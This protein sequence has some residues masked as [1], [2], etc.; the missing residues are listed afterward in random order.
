MPS[1]VGYIS[2]VLA[3]LLGII[4][5]AGNYVCNKVI[6]KYQTRQEDVNLWFASGLWNMN[7]QNTKEAKCYFRKILKSEIATS[8]TKQQCAI[9]NLSLMNFGDDILSKD[10]IDYCFNFFSVD[11]DSENA[12]KLILYRILPLIRKDSLNKAI[13]LYNQIDE[14]NHRYS[15]QLRFLSQINSPADSILSY[16]LANKYD[17][18]AQYNERIF[19]YLVF[20]TVANAKNKEELTLLAT[21]ISHRSDPL[22]FEDMYFCVYDPLLNIRYNRLDFRK[23]LQQTVDSLLPILNPHFKELYKQ[24]LR[25]YTNGIGAT[26][27][28]NQIVGDRNINNIIHNNK[29]N[30]ELRTN[31]IFYPIKHINGSYSIFNIYT[32]IDTVQLNNTIKKSASGA[33]NTISD[34]SR[35]HNTLAFN[36]IKGQIINVNNN[37]T[38]KIDIIDTL[39]NYR[40]GLATLDIIPNVSSFIQDNDFYL[41]IRRGT[42]LSLEI[43]KIGTNGSCTLIPFASNKFY[44]DYRNFCFFYDEDRKELSVEFEKENWT[45][46]N[47]VEKVRGVITAEV[48]D[49]IYITS[50]NF[51]NPAAELF[52]KRLE[53][54]I[55]FQAYIINSVKFNGREIID[56]EFLDCI[57]SNYNLN[58]VKTA[59]DNM[60]EYV[61]SELM[62][63]MSILQI[64][65]T[66][67]EFSANKSHNYIILVKQTSIN[68]ME[69]LD[70]YKIIN[71]TKLKSITQNIQKK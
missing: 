61:L 13:A 38:S 21:A 28:V 7:N 68:E 12:T 15:K 3:V 16:L 62:P 5:P 65:F 37:I 10:E 18:D 31:I 34:Q 9:W 71:S 54:N 14:Y 26:H 30:D 36:D 1:K 23:V 27:Y 48:R 63:D 64:S 25:N 53:E 6:E 24:E 20:T 45:Q 32:T 49:S 41:V 66:Q 11:S 43:Y 44:D 17:F 70:I 50:I 58:Y 42:I 19:D 55:K 29:K 33:I 47:A 8:Y 52:I 57:K 67:D 4:L 56:A 35:Y 59:C 22:E 60:Y 39:I 40:G 69:I 2:S 51:K 46:A